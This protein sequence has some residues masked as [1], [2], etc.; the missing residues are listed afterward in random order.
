MQYRTIEHASV[1]F[2]KQYVQNI[3]VLKNLGTEFIYACV[4]NGKIGISIILHGEAH[5]NVDGVWQRQ[6]PVSIYGL[7]KK[8]QF[9]KMS[10]GYH[11]V[12][13]GFTPHYLQLFL[14]DR[15]SALEERNATDLNYLFRKSSVENLFENLFCCNT[16]AQIL[17]S[18]DFFLRRHLS[19]EKVDPRI[20]MAHKLIIEQ[21]V[22]KIEDICSSLCISSTGLRNLFREKVGISPKDLVKITRIKK[23]LEYKIT[24]DE[25]L[26]TLAYQLNYYDQAHFIHDFKEATELTPK[27]YFLNQRLA[28]DFYNYG[29]WSYDSFAEK[30][31]S[32]I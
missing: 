22:L 30:N 31:N 26:T 25:T 32:A 12:N 24:D 8:V 15:L 21:Q 28:F 3:Y 9:H 19:N 16:D 2:L 18:I 13:I 29:R 6:A 20:S 1:P 27:Q 7:V 10:M 14:Q 17:N 23:A 5:I 4:P 11:E